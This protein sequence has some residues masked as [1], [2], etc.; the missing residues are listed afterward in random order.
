M[1]NLRNILLITS[2]LVMLSAVPVIAASFRVGSIHVDA[3]VKESIFC[4]PACDGTTS[5]QLSL[6]PGEQD[7]FGVEIHNIASIPQFVR[8]NIDVSP[9]DGL[10]LDI[11]PD[12]EGSLFEIPANSF[13][14]QQVS[15]TV[16]GGAAPQ[17]YDIEIRVTRGG[18]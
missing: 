8:L 16:D 12:N 3:E 6:W 1:N 13:V 10:D 17:V 5:L 9:E 15:L 11:Y 18:P 4:V 7:D 14:F 2:V